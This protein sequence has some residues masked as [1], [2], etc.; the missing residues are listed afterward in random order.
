MFGRNFS[1]TD[2]FINLWPKQQR[3][4]KLHKKQHIAKTHGDTRVEKFARLTLKVK[5]TKN[6][7]AQTNKPQ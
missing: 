4:T 2:K 1:P 6:E 3:T 7:V 5:L